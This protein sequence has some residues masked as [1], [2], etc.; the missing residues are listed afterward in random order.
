MKKLIAVLLVVVMLLSLAACAGKGE[1]KLV[2]ATATFGQKFSPFFST[3]AYDME[4]VD[5]FTG[6]LLASDRGGAIIYDGIKG[7]TINYNGT[8]YTYHGMGNVEVVQNDNGS[9]D[10]KLTMRDDIKFS[11]GTPANID[12]VIFGLY[13]MCDPTYDGSSTLYALPIEGMEEYRSGMESLKNVILA[14]GPDTVSEFADEEQST[15][16]WNALNAAGSKFCQSIA[17]YCMANYAEEGA[18]DFKS[19]VE[20]WGYEAENAEDMWTQM[21]EIYGYDL[22]DDGINCEV[23]D[24]SIG[25]FLAEELGDRAGEFEAGVKTGEGAANIAGIER[26]GDYS[27]TVHMTAFDATAIYDMAL[28][29][30]PLHWYGDKSKYDYENNQFG[31]TKGDLSGVKAKTT[32]PLGCGPY[33][34]EGYEKGVVT[35]KANP[36][37]FE[38]E[39][40][41][42]TILFQESSDADYVP[43]IITGTFDLALPSIS[44]DTVK[45][46]EDANNGKLTG[47]T[48]STYLIDYRG[49]GYLGINADIVNVDGDP[50]SDASKALRKGFMTLFAVYRDTVINSYYG[51]RASVIQ[52]P[53]SNTSWAAPQ[54]ADEGYRTAYSLNADGADIYTDEM[55]DQQKYEAAK[56]AAISW[57]K[58]AGFTYDE[59]SGKFTDVTETYE[60][61][62]PGDGTQDHPA[63]GIAVA[64]SEALAEMGITLQVNDVSSSVWNNALEAN[65]AM[66]WAAAW[67]ATVDPDMTQVYHSDN[68]HGQGTNSNHYNVADAA[69]DEL[70]VEGRGSS[71]TEYRKSIYK[72]AMEIIMDWGCELPLYQRKDCIVTSTARV[73]NDTMP[74][75]LTPY[76]GWYAE[77]ET[78]MTK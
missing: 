2:Y 32:Q 51:D 37:Y 9:V 42:E 41:I 54:P 78:L 40:K 77:I 48:L 47:E 27:M 11:D 8:D 49:Y 57:F 31:F 63:Y 43:G 26:T 70:I 34:F 38:G 61:L 60:V 55:T 10:Y 21:I 28:Y 17:D 13:V 30:T 45:A 71:D 65:T 19:A 68:A 33:S 75:D 66:M 56:E 1:A 35:M 72:S 4:V 15:Y 12:D 20:L 6:A 18:V 25:D 44:E 62:I 58:A 59:A 5:L 36:Y 39:P 67:Q 24:T 22:S 64:A 7:E 74:K 14:E 69:L 16:F 23:A 29:I 76:W 53:I 50:A 73:D 52:Y 46:I 3:T